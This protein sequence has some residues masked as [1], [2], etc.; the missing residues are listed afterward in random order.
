MQCIFIY[1]SKESFEGNKIAGYKN[2]PI[3]LHLW[4]NHRPLWKIALKMDQISHE[5]FKKIAAV[6]KQKQYYDSWW[7]KSVE[8]LSLLKPLFF[9]FPSG[10][11]QI[12]LDTH[13]I[14]LSYAITQDSS[15]S[16]T[17]NI[18]HWHFESLPTGLNAGCVL[19]SSKQFTLNRLRH[20]AF[21]AFIQRK[22][23]NAFTF[24]NSKM[25]QS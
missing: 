10:F 8:N 15:L 13:E 7:V 21:V 14:F 4:P 18:I 24:Q 22:L 2:K 1:Y 3:F 20:I 11:R 16:P 19:M 25:I 9:C 5:G 6:M 12:L 17:K 23:N